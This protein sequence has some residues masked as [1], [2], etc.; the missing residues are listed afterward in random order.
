MIKNVQ[1]INTIFPM[2]LKDDNNVCTTSFKPGALFI[3]LNGRSDLS[4]RK[5]YKKDI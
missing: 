4:K 5:T 1:Q 2:G 3:T